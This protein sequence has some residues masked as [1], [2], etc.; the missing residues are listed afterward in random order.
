MATSVR[1]CL[2]YDTLQWDFITFKMDNISRRK[3]I[4]DTDVVKDVTSTCQVL[5]HVWQYDFDDT[6]LSTE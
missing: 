4:A 3:P 2:S 5:L 6:A 1:I